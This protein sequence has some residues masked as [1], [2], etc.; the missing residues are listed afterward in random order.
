MNL[1]IRK[2]RSRYSPVESAGLRG[3]QPVQTH[4]ARRRAAAGVKLFEPQTSLSVSSRAY[5]ARHRSTS[6]RWFVSPLV[7]QLS[8][9]MTLLST[10]PMRTHKVAKGHA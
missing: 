4:G 1:H 10:F 8:R 3:A 5:P 6:F 9:A 2:D 7:L